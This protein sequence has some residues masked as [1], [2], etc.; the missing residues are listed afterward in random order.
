M[1]K[2]L[3][4]MILINT[5]LQ[6]EPLENSKFTFPSFFMLFSWESRVHSLVNENIF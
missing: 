3:F 5:V 6:E 4:V 2:I 1:K